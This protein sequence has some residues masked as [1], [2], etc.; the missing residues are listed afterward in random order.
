MLCC[1]AAYKCCRMATVSQ[2]HGI[3]QVEELSEKSQDIIQ[4]YLLRAGHA[5]GRYAAFCAATGVVPWGLMDA[6]DYDELLKVGPPT[7]CLP[8]GS[9]GGGGGGGGRGCMRS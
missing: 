5:K 3:L 6:D 8:G 4:K 7:V 1:I 9:G 2:S